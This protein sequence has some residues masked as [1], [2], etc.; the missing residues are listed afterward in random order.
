V[1]VIKIR[2]VNIQQTG[3]NLLEFWTSIVGLAQANKHQVAGPFS[4]GGVGP[5]VDEF[6]WAK[7]EK[8]SGK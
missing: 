8:T 7:L 4:G 6:E 5:E 2:Y 3:A 1:W